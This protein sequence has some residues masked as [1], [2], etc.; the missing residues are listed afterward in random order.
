MTVKVNNLIQKPLDGR[1]DMELDLVL[2]ENVV[3]KTSGKNL[4]YDTKMNSK[5]EIIEDLYVK[6]ESISLDGFPLGERYIHQLITINTDDGNHVSTS[7]LGFNGEV[8]LEFA[9]DNAFFQV[10]KIKN[11]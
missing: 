10:L 8:V 11:L 9:E 3:I 5:G 1:V 7:Y 4:K 2:P 6:I